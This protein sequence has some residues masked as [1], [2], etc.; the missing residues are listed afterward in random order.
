MTPTDPPPGPAAAA[1]ARP[2]AL[3]AELTHACPLHC[4]Y[5]SNPLS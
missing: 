2:W 5:C 1:P 3:L 4:G